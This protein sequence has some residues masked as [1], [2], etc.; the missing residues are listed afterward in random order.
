MRFNPDE[1]RSKIFPLIQE[2]IKALKP[3]IFVQKIYPQLVEH[4]LVLIAR[5]E[6]VYANRDS[7]QSDI[8]DDAVEFDEW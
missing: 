7:K 6:E 1:Q 4:V 8:P 2:E 5:A 3:D